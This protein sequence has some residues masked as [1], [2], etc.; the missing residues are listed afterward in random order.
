MQGLQVCGE[1]C[2]ELKRAAELGWRDT[3][4]AAEDLREMARVRRWKSLFRR[5][6]LISPHFGMTRL[7]LYAA[8]SYFVIPQQWPP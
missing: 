7:S 8:I 2:G 5:K 1:K 4:H 6:G 3:G